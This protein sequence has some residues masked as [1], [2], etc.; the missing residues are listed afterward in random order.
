MGSM[1]GHN[2]VTI[3]LLAMT[4]VVMPMFNALTCTCVTSCCSSNSN[5]DGTSEINYCCCET[6]EDGCCQGN[7]SKTTDRQ[8]Q[9]SGVFLPECDG[10]CLHA[11][12]SNLMMDGICESEKYL[13]IQDY[14][15]T[16]DTLS[17]VAF[18][19]HYSIN[20]SFNDLFPPTAALNIS[21][22]VFLC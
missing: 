3:T 16:V 5:A 13:L 15:S 7:G 4:V 11:I 9:K 14:L 19:S 18:S 12:G 8:Q 6:S 17:F 1:Q 20:L 22:C 2:M 10:M 21:L